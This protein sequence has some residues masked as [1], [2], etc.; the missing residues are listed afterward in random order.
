M[1]CSAEVFKEE[2]KHKHLHFHPPLLE[3]RYILYVNWTYV[4]PSFCTHLWC[5]LTAW[6]DIPVCGWKNG[7]NGTELIGKY[8]LNFFISIGLVWM[9]GASQNNEIDLGDITGGSS[10]LFKFSNSCDIFNKYECERPKPHFLV[11]GIW[12]GDC[13]NHEVSFLN[14]GLIEKLLSIQSCPC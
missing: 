13:S 7:C 3:K 2:M 1:L 8:P 14:S 6:P 5:D 10:A 12:I 9:N 11:S 4:F